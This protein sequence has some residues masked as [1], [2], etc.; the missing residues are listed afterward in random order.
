MVKIVHCLVVFFLFVHAVIAQKEET[1]PKKYSL[2]INVGTN[3]WFGANQNYGSAILKTGANTFNGMG[4]N[5]ALD[6]GYFINEVT[7]LETGIGITRNFLSSEISAATLT[8]GD[9]LNPATGLIYQTNFLPTKIESKF[10]FSSL[11]FPFRIRYL[12]TKGNWRFTMSTGILN[13]F[14][15]DQKFSGQVTFSNRQPDEGS[16]KS[17]YSY[18]TYTASVSLSAGVRFQLNGN[19][20][21]QLEPKMLYQITRVNKSGNEAHPFGVAAIF[22][23][24]VVF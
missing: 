8:F 6:C 9:L 17:H 15:I 13:N 23:S 2:G 22:S 5:F 18:T 21:L 7:C 24:G 14:L 11:S 10:V 1:D 20:Y 19:Y 4:F 3:H 12:T 16:A